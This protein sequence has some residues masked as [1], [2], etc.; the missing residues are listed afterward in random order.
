MAGW[1]FVTA[2]AP[3]QEHPKTLAEAEKLIKALK[4]QQGEISLEGGLAKLNVPSQFKYLNPDDTRIV[5]ESL[6][7]NPPAKKSLGMLLPSDRS[8]LSP[9]R[10]GVVISYAG[11]GY[12][13]DDDAGKI[14]Y[15]ELLKKMQSAVQDNNKKR[16]QQGYPAI[17]LVG[18][19][20]PPRYDASTHKLYWA[21]ELKFDGESA[22]TLNYDIRILGRRGVLVLS[23]V[24]A[25]DQL[26]EIEG[27]TP[28]ILGMVNFTDGNRYADFDPKIDKV[29]TYGIAAL[30]AGGVAAKLGLFKVLWVLVL[31]AKKFIVVGFLAVAAWFRR[32]FRK[33]KKTTA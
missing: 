8:P 26:G 11:D 21:K 33:E 18:W 27:E 5:L 16:T 10:W 4:Y 20:T 17:Q 7:G 25:I 1:V 29:A 28:Q 23:A 30:V 9:D 3:A 13:K 22:N 12:V 6:W 32:I 19:A 15:D 2:L 14:K 24:A 31:A